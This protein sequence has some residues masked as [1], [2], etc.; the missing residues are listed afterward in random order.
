M[1][2]ASFALLTVALASL[3]VGSAGATNPGLFI[4]GGTLIDGT[5]AAPRPNPGILILNGRFA[6]L[7][8]A[9]SVP[10]D[11][12]RISAEGKWILPAMFEMH[13][14]ITFY[15]ADPGEQEDDVTNAFR[16][17]RFLER[18]QEIG[19]TTVRDPASRNQVGYSVSRAQRKGLI[20]GAR[21]YTAGPIIT[22]TAGHPTEIQ[23]LMPSMWAVEADGPWEFRK[24]VRE[25][26][27][28]GADF[29]KLTPP[30]NADELGAA[31]SEAHYWKRRITVQVGGAQDF[32]NNSA[33]VAVEAGVDSFEHLYPYGGSEVIRRLAA[34]GIYV[35]P[36]LG[37]HLRE[38]EGRYTHKPDWLAKHLGHTRDNMLEE[39][40]QMVAL[41]V[42]FGVGVDSNAQD[43]P[44]IDQLYLQELEALSGAGLS[45][46]RV[47]QSA[48]LHAAEVMGLGEEA[49]SIAVGKW[50]DLIVLAGNPL[51]EL[52][53][54]VSP[55]IV[56][57]AGEIVHR[58]QEPME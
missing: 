33:D 19:V 39:F 51:E 27:K 1:R 11:V 12:Q 25:A 56:V 53:V 10:S 49:G 14:H 31:V 15:L 50:G 35:T 30:F 58:Q 22:T 34:K 26:I 52:A 2:R 5:G 54:A 38:F 41:G 9:R 16:T 45:P 13:G 55:E 23:P 3:P 28:L 43:L 18:Y 8:D 36:T 40:R 57:Q 47:I 17:E 29:I 32:H 21:Y 42:K 48:T 7:G 4:D 20:G 24:R 37:Y 6:A 44:I 46:M